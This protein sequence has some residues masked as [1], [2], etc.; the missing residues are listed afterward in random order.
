MSNTVRPTPKVSVPAQS[1]R[2][3]LRTPSSFSERTL[4][5]VPMMPI[6]TPTQKMACQWIPASTPP[7]SRPRN[8]PA[9]AATMLTPRAMPRWL[10]GNASVRMADD[11][12]MSMAPPT[13]WT[14]RQPISQI[15]PPSS[16]KGSKDSATAARVNT[17]NPM[18]YIF[19][20]PNMSPSRPKGTTSTAVTTR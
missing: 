5:M 6:G 17:T 2:P 3:G 18:L 12:D 14:T 20:R 10:A 15:A 16:W 7:I 4:Q 19:T 9:T 8:E 1:I 11:E 13:P